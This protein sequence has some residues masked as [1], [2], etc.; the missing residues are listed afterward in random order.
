MVDSSAT[1]EAAAVDSALAA[2]LQKEIDWRHLI[3]VR[4]EDTWVELLRPSVSAQ[5]IDYEKSKIIDGPPD[6][7]L[8]PRPIPLPAILTIEARQ[9]N[10]KQGSSWGAL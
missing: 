3:R 5:G 6:G 8:P 2:R 10:P 1:Q 7:A 4:T 9:G